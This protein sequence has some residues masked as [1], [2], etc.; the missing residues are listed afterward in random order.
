MPAAIYDPAQMSDPGGPYGPAPPFSTGPPPGAPVSPDGRFWWDGRQW[1]PVPPPATPPPS[2]VTPP[3]PVVSGPPP[4]APRSADG[5]FWWD[6]TQWAPVPPPVT[7]PFPPAAPPWAPS[8]QFAPPAVAAP[9]FAGPAPGQWPAPPAPVAPRPSG[10]R[11]LVATVVALVVVAGAGAA[12]YVL[13]RPSSNGLTSESPAQIVQAASAATQKA[14]GFEMSGTGNF[15]SGVTAIDFKVH[16]NDID[17]TLTL[18]GSSVDLDVIGGNVYFN[19]PAAFWTAEGLPS[20]ATGDYAGKWVEA[21]AGSSTASAFSGVSSLTDISSLLGNHGTLA[22]G[23]TGTVNGQ[24]AV[25]VKDTSD[26][27]ILAVASSGPAYPLRLSKT[28]GSEAGTINFSNWNSVPAF[29]PPPSPL[30]IP[31]S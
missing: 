7:P 30:T 28:S 16:G 22:S 26:G 25:F 19:A 21:P 20:S 24:S 18:D 17:G 9:P 5:R 4:G 2:P 8:P 6:G 3:P 10:A 31:G 13:T 14:S 12:V 15:G 27:S 23:G 29:T 1:V 11:W